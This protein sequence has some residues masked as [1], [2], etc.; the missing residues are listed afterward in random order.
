MLRVLQKILRIIH[1]VIFRD[2]PSRHDL[3]LRV[4]GN[5]LPDKIGTLER[6][7]SLATGEQPLDTHPG[8][9]TRLGRF[10]Q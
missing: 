5:Q 3:Y 6:S 9:Q 4:I 10:D 1:Q 2:A 8:N 7:G